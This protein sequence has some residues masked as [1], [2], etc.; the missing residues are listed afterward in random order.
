MS[1]PIK[2]G[3][4][5]DHPLFRQGLRTL[6]QTQADM[7]VV[8]EAANGQELLEMLADIPTDVILLD[9]EMP[10]MDGMQACERVRALYPELKVLILTMHQD[11]RLIQFMLKQGANGYVTK[12]AKWDEL[13]TAIRKVM[14]QDY[15]FSDLVGLAMLQNI[16]H[17]RMGVPSIGPKISLTK[18]ETEVLD[19][20]ARGHNT[21]EIAEKLFISQRTVEG[22]RSNLLKRLDVNNIAGLIIKALKLNL[23]V[24]E[25][26]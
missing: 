21:P 11:A 26:L 22:H 18:R 5:D 7:E 13:Q 20:I 8:L 25:D 16:K 9:L 1:S 24:L 10:Q 6:M 3:L 15:Y 23:I 4:V 12:T 17:P 19:L 14:K 2:I